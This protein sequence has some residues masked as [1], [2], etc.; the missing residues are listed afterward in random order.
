MPLVSPAQIQPQLYMYGPQ[1]ESLFDGQQEDMNIPQNVRSF[2]Q[3]Q[4]P[5]QMSQED[6]KFQSTAE[7]QTREKDIR[8]NQALTGIAESLGNM[9]FTTAGDILLHTKPPEPFVAGGLRAEGDRLE[10]QLT[11]GERQSLGGAFGMELP[12]GLTMD[13]LEKLAGPLGS[14]MNRKAAMALSQNKA[15]KMQEGREARLALAEQAHQDTEDARHRLSDKELT[16]LDTMDSALQLI[17]G[18]GLDKA[19]IDTGP[20]AALTNTVAGWVGMDDPQVTEFR[21][22]VVTQLNQAIRAQTGVS[23]SPGEVRR[24][25][26]TLPLINDND[27]QFR[28]KLNSVARRLWQARDRWLT[29]RARAGKNVEPFKTTS[30]DTNKTTSED[31]KRIRFELN[32]RIGSVPAEQWDAYL[33]SNPSAKEI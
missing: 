25:E 26:A 24:I 14:A 22:R 4:K 27:A 2:V 17:G 33:D 28:A 9:K 6:Q 8:R 32:G 18:I 13:R 5:S 20:M 30:E 7:D 10:N 16:Q 31:T 23:L 21:S 12:P 11:T 1:Q 15:D 3:S 19:K 29:N